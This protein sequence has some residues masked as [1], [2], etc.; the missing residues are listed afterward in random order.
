VSDPC[1]KFWLKFQ[2]ICKI[3]VFSMVVEILRVALKNITYNLLS[4]MT[5]THGQRI[6]Q[7][8]Q[9]P[10]GRLHLALYFFSEFKLKLG[11]HSSSLRKGKLYILDVIFPVQLVEISLLLLGGRT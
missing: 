2:E 7:L 1:S 3:M 4:N 8:L 6:P 5:C 11:S 10:S 9:M